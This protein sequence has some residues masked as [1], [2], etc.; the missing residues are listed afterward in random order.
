MSEHDEKVRRLLKEHGQ[1]FAQEA[2]IH[3]RDTPSALYQLAVLSLL[4]S[5][6]IRANIAVA[7][8][9]ELFAAGWRTPARMAEAT[10]QQR[11]DALGRA[12]YKR[13]DESTSTALGDG[14]QL[15]L[16]TWSGDLRKLRADADHDPKAI[17]EQLQ[18]L[19]RIGPTGA[20]IFC[21]EAQGLWPELRP[22]FDKRALDGA[23]AAGLPTKPDALADLVR[24]DDLPRL[25][26]ALVRSTL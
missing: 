10:W 3:L 2:G 16:D 21:R 20:E 9:K 22:S 4:S 6:R 12:S 26:A 18:R 19:P 13:Y 25:A 1:T 5:T 11:V 8:A 23:R 17:R 14:A 7:A 15:I 24:P